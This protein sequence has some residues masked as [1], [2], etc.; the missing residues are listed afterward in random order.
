MLS[1]RFYHC[2]KI[3]FVTAPKL[4]VHKLHLLLIAQKVQL[5]FP[6][7][8]LLPELPGEVFTTFFI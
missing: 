3:K 5:V 4:E 1:N 7:F 6:Y 2:T 8:N